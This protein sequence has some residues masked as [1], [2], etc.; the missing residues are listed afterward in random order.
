MVRAVFWLCLAAVVAAS[1]DRGPRDPE[2]TLD[3]VRGG[4]L[5]VGWTLHPPWCEASARR[6]GPG[7][8]DADLVRALAREL[9]ARVVWVDGDKEELLGRLE[10]FELDLVACGVPRSSPWKKRVGLTRVPS[11]GHT[12]ATPPG[13]NGWLLFVNRSL[14]RQHRDHGRSEM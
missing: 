10:R 5:R 11:G 6:D 9:D 7:G 12:L 3:R 4:Q 13:E 8:R 14:A 2:G 1:C